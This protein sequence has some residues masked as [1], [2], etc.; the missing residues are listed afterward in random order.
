MVPLRLVWHRVSCHNEWSKMP[1]NMSF[2]SNGVDQVR[3]LRK[4]STQLRSANVC[5]N[6]AS[7][8]SFAS[9]FVQWRNGHKRP[10]TWVL[11]PME[12]IG[13]VHCEKFQR[14]FILRNCALMLPVQTVFHW[15][16]CSNKM[17]RNAPKHEFWVQWSESGAGAFVAKNSNATSFSKLGR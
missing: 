8:V 14:N 12:W 9:T 13:C 3:S 17:V 6:G 1:Q 7:S 11:G 5:V 10:K 2:G 4:F 16:S 15:P